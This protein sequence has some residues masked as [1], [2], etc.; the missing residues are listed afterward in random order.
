MSAGG[1]IP[2][3]NN[4]RRG[5]PPRRV[6]VSS[7]PAPLE[8]TPTRVVVCPYHTARARLCRQRVMRTTHSSTPQAACFLKPP[9]VARRC[10]KARLAPAASPWPS[11]ARPAASPS[12]WTRPATP[13]GA[14]TA[15]W[16]CRPP[17]HPSSTTCWSSRQVRCTARPR[18]REEAGPATQPACDVTPRGLDTRWHHQ[19]PGLVGP[20]CSLSPTV[21]VRPHLRQPSLSRIELRHPVRAQVHQVSGSGRFKMFH[22]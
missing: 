14:A 8:P 15:A 6:E 18:G 1:G 2:D 4:R 17:P 22:G 16:S 19:Q 9:R 5:R 11:T 13:R 12:E 20:C 7:Y 10:P 21:C 3:G